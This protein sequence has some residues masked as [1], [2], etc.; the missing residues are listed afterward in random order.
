[1]KTFNIPTNGNTPAKKTGNAIALLLQNSVNNIRGVVI[2]D[3]DEVTVTRAIH[4]LH[5]DRQIYNCTQ[6]DGYL[7]LWIQY[8]K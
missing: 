5:Y 8:Q 6:E 3:N 4:Q 7:F 1:M 2:C